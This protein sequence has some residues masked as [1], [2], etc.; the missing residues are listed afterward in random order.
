MGS[1]Y[2]GLKMAEAL[3]ALGVETHLVDGAPQPLPRLDPDMGALV[4]EAL[5]DFGTVLHLNQ[6]VAGF[7]SGAGGEVSGVVT[8]A[9][10]LPARVVALTPSPSPC[11]TR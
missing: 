9:G 10:T 11:G 3:C 5:R 1:G 6:E 7:E 2:V 8:S 4:A